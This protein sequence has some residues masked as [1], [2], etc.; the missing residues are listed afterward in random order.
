MIRL[1]LNIVLIISIFLSCY[2]EDAFLTLWNPRVGK[3]APVTLRLPQPDT[4]LGLPD[5]R[6]ATSAWQ[7]GPPQEIVPFMKKLDEQDIQLIDNYR[8]HLLAT[9]HRDAP[10][11]LFTM[12]FMAGFLAV[13]LDLPPRAGS[14][15]ASSPNLVLTLLI[16][17]LLLL[18]VLLLA[19][20]L[21]VAMLPF[22]VLP[23]LLV[24][25]NQSRAAAVGVSL[26]AAVL[27]SLFVD[28]SY[29]GVI[30]ILVA[31]L[32]ALAAAYTLPKRLAFLWPAV[33]IGTANAIV[34][35]VLN[36]PDWQA[37][38]SLALTLGP[39]DL[40]SLSELGTQPVVTGTALA[41]CGGFLAGPLA[42]LLL[43][44][45]RATR[46]LSSAI[47]LRRFADLDHPALKKLISDA[48]GTYQH[49]MGVAHLAQ[50]V[51]EAVD[52]DSLLLRIGGYYH[53]I[54]K[55]V[56]PNDYIENQFNSP[57][58]HN[59]LTPLESTQRI[60]RH[61]TDGVRLAAEYRLPKMVVDL[62]PQHHGTLLLEYFYTKAVKGEPKTEVRKR[63]FRYPGPKPQSREAAILMVADAVEAA[64]R[65]L[66]QP[67]RHTF[68]R[69]VR[70]IIVKRIAD[71]QFSECDLDTIQIEKITDALVDGLEAMFHGRIRYPWQQ[72]AKR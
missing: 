9:S 25:L 48:R 64:S 37:A 22:G 14:R 40:S 28:R 65:T 18:K 26:A 66:E 69:L 57:N 71:G 1:L 63:D 44:V 11:I 56:S 47:K 42:L 10:F 31:S 13:F 52:A 35:S 67:N 46:Y 19:A 61:V 21:P 29:P 59:S 68:D 41:F 58:P 23:L 62:I 20:P 50:S 51:G 17:H 33:L 4:G 72:A 2:F 60:F 16:L 38:A 8:R 6:Q 53:D 3:R 27:A 12:I 32:T 7:I 70:L 30:A 34:F 36:S 15:S 5:S 39:L 54:G 24:A 45:L 49:S 55:M 43:P